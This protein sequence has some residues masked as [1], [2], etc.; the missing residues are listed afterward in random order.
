MKHKITTVVFG[1]L[2]YDRDDSKIKNH[3][4]QESTKEGNW[5]L[6]GVT[7]HL[8]GGMYKFFWRERLENE[9]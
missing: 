7:N 5:I 6:A 9:Q 1:M 4:D 3:C 2:E 8:G